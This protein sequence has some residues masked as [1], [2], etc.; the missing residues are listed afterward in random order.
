MLGRIAVSFAIG[1]PLRCLLRRWARDEAG[2]TAVEY[3]LI[4]S[5]V[6]LFILVSVFLVGNALDNMFHAVQTKIS[7]WDG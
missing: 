5:G 6:A 4:L 3:G 7:T 1:S 2:V